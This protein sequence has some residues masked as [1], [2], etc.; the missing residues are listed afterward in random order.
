MSHNKQNLNMAENTAIFYYNAS[1]EFLLINLYFSSILFLQINIYK[2]EESFTHSL[3]N[4]YQCYTKHSAKKFY[5]RVKNGVADDFVQKQ[6][7]H[8]RLHLCKAVVHLSSL[9]VYPNK[10]ICSEDKQGIYVL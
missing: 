10:R 5:E 3:S 8:D 2:V 4:I 6:G 7:P 9:L 1:I